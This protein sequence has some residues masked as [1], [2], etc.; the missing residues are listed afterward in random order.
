MSSK[1]KMFRV[2]FVFLVL[3]MASMACNIKDPKKPSGPEANAEEA[4]EAIVAVDSGIKD[5]ASTVADTV[6]A[7]AEIVGMPTPDGSA[8]EAIIEASPNLLEKAVEIAKSIA[9]YDSCLS[10]CD[11]SDTGCRANCRALYK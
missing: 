5:A 11:D 2:L 10:D 4:L 8:A 9:R 3:A 6:D 7:A 1:R